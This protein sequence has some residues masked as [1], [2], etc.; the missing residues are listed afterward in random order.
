MTRAHL[1]GIITTVTH[2]V[3]GGKVKSNRKTKLNKKTDVKG[4]NV[5]PNRT[6]SFQYNVIERKRKRTLLTLT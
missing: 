1:P 3:T 4:L 2:G 5:T 6:Q